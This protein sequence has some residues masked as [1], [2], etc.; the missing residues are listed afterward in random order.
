MTGDVCVVLSTVGNGE[1]AER[2]AAVLVEERLAACVNVVSGMHSVYRWEGSI[3]R[4]SEV[5]LIVKTVT[6][7]LA[8]L[9]WRLHEIHPYELPEFVVLR[10]E[11]S[12]RYGAWLRD[13]AAG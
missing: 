8:A 2:I 1:D 3:Q 9:E 5:L 12:D 11:A 7:R 10:G 13:S 6:A 4:D